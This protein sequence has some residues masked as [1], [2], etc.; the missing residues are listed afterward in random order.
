MKDIEWN[1]LITA[2]GITLIIIAMVFLL[3]SF[4]VTA[5]VILTIAGLLMVTIGSSIN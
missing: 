2:I 5:W 3:I 1:K 4:N